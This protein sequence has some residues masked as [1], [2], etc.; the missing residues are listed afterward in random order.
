VISAAPVV[1]AIQN[2]PSDPPQLV[3]EWLEERGIDVRVVRAFAGETVPDH[4]PES[5]SGILALGGEMGAYDDEVASWLPGERGLLR[6]AVA[7]DVPVIGLCLG[8][9][10]LAMALGGEVTVG[11]A[12]EI[13]LVAVRRTVEGLI[14]PVVS[15]VVPISGDAIPSTHWHLDNIVRL[16][17][18][19]VLLLTNDVCRVQG[20]RVGDCAYGFQMHPE[21]DANT[22]Q[23][24]AEADL[25]SSSGS[26]WDV[27]SLAAQVRAS[28]HDLITAWRPAILAW[29][30]LVWDHS[31]E[32]AGATPA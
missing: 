26:G 15:Q 1:L 30:D 5:V 6:D 27:M 4:V 9:Q 23:S 3:G 28:E 14:D 29:S 20:F 10:L 25:G 31:R 13:G 7:R 8:G 11:P 24:W 32:T 16:P 12:T 21:V 17:D 2:D 19:A 22:F 18:E